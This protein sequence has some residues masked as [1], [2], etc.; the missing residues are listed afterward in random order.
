MGIRQHPLFNDFEQDIG[1]IR[2]LANAP[3][4]ITAAGQAQLDALSSDQQTALEQLKA[5]QGGRLA[6]SQQQQALSG[7]LS[8]GANE[9]TARAE[10]RQGGLFA[11]GLRGEFA[12]QGENVRARDFA[13]QQA[14]QERAIFAAPAASSQLFES[15]FTDQLA[16]ARADLLRDEGKKNT[17]GA[18]GGAIGGTIGTIYGGPVGGAAGSAGGSA[19]F[20]SFA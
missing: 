3:T 8:A 19:L 20:R 11:Q 14:L 5:A 9:R 2:S 18:V 4:E 1:R 10:S 16:Q 12:R 6:S 13:Q 17:L 7:G 15:V